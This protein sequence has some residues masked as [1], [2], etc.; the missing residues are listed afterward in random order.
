MLPDGIAG[1][2]RSA[3][4]RRTVLCPARK[5]QA[6]LIQ[7]AST[8]QL[9]SLGQLGQRPARPPAV[10]LRRHPGAIAPGLSGFPWPRPAHQLKQ[11]GE[12]PGVCDLEQASCFVFSLYQCQSQRAP[13]VVITVAVVFGIEEL[14]AART[15]REWHSSR[16]AVPH[17]QEPDSRRSTAALA[18]RPSAYGFCRTGRQGCAGGR[19]GAQVFLLLRRNPCSMT[20]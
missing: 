17:L 8:P 15:C 9:A 14:A 18:A 11:A 1:Q 12:A 20:E 16:S 13:P 5:P 2:D 7:H 3:H 6:Y 4:V 19:F 10:G